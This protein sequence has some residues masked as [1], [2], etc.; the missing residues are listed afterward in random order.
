VGAGGYGQPILAGIRLD[1]TRMILEGALPAALMALA[2]QA[3]FDGVER[4]AAHI[5]SS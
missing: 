2:V 3:A 4:L 1:D 5:A